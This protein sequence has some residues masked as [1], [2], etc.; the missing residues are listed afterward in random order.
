MARILFVN[1]EG[2]IA[3]AERSLLLLIEHLR[4]QFAISVAC[5]AASPLAAALRSMQIDSFGLDGPANRSS[6]SILGLARWLRTSWRLIRIVS[7]AKPDI[8]HANSF[9]SAVPSIL[10]AVVMRKKLL[11]HARDLASFG[12]FARICGYFCHRI[13]AVSCCVKNALVQDG[14]SPDKIRVVYN[15]VDSCSFSQK[16]EGANSSGHSKGDFVFANVG[17]F[18]PWKNHMLFLKAASDVGG[19]QAD[20]RFVLVGDDLFGRDGGYKQSVIDYAENSPIADR[21]ALWG[22]RDDMHEVWPGID[23]LVHTAEREP[24]GRVI[25][26]AMANRIPV[27][28]VGSGGP[29]EIIEDQ[30]TGILVQAD[31]VEEL[32]RA[33]LGVVRDRQFARRLADAGYEHAASNFTADKTAVQIKEVYGELL[34]V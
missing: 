28:A 26:E 25:V 11:L 10:V 20:A 16:R 27:I 15:G 17:Q 18:V 30:K 31:D 4:A 1:L 29:K 12:F 34:A 22:W 9:Y 13:I 23:C 3:G 5:P 7:K 8:I 6:F 2:R 14:V 24:F 33:M 32:G 19:Q 21:I